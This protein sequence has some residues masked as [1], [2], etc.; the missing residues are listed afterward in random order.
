MNTEPMAPASL[1][2][3]YEPGLFYDEMFAASGDPRPHYAPFFDELARMAPA[4]FEES[5]RRAP[6]N[7]RSS[8]RKT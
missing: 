1:L 5:R 2:S 8:S 4:Q 3:D 6:R 7:N